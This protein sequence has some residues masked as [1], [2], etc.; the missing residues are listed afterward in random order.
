[1]ERRLHNTLR[2]MYWLAALVVL[3]HL[4]G[5]TIVYSSADVEGRIVDADTGEPVAGAVV[6]GIW[7]LESYPIH[8]HYMEDIIHVSESVTDEEGRYRLEGFALKFVGHKSGSLYEY[9]PVI[10]AFVE[11][12]R[13]TSVTRSEREFAGIGPYRKSPLNGREITLISE[14]IDSWGSAYAWSNII[15]NVLD[16]DMSCNHVY[17]LPAMMD[18]FERIEL[19]YSKYLDSRVYG[20]RYRGMVKDCSE[21]VGQK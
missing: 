1:M 6:V 7:Q 15:N 16:D 19:Q 17:Q 5:C 12:Y 2:T 9:D 18:L 4:S 8:N 21:S 10:L 14:V 20:W 13:P 11:G 3:I